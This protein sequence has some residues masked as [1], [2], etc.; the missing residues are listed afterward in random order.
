MK[1]YVAIYK[2]TGVVVLLT[3]EILC[4]TVEFEIDGMIFKYLVAE[5]GGI[6]NFEIVG[7]F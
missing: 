4:S 5:L 7:E 3:T 2:T 6:S 1:Q